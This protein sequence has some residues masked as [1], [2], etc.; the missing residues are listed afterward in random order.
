MSFG[1]NSLVVDPWGKVIFEGGK[2]EE[3][4]FSV[5]DTEEVKKVRSFLTVYEDRVPELY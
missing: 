3:F 2:G 1:G 5:I 4:A